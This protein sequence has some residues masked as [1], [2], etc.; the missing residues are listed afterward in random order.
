MFLI[1]F[2]FFFVFND[3]QIYYL[4]H[5]I[6]SAALSFNHDNLL[7]VFSFLFFAFEAWHFVSIFSFFDVW[8]F[9]S[10]FLFYLLCLQCSFEKVWN[11]CSVYNVLF[12]MFS[13]WQLKFI[14]IA[15][16]AIPCSTFGESTTGLPAPRYSITSI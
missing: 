15:R 13:I 1:F 2:F 12:L 14:F 7:A 10:S 8:H 3:Y 4:T 6:L 11:V 16:V 5:G 9:V